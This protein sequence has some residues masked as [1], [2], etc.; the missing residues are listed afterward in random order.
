LHEFVSGG[1]WILRKLRREFIERN[2]V[3]AKVG[4]P[5]RL[6]CRY[7]GGAANAVSPTPADQKPLALLNRS[8]VVTAALAAMMVAVAFW[9]GARNKD[10]DEWVLHSLAVR[11][12]LTAV[13]T[14]VQAAETGQRGFLITGRDSYLA[15]YDNAVARLPA[16]L[17]EVDKL[18][19]ADA[20]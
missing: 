15:P 12:Q 8:L 2:H 19:G 14:L 20:P 16:T 11:D 18:V 9:L 17:D 4:A 10:D 7:A 3:D 1:A 6:C 5:F 13:R